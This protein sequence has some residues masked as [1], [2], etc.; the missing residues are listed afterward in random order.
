MNELREEIATRLVTK[1]GAEKSSAACKDVI[2]DDEALAM[3]VG[4]VAAETGLQVPD[5]ELSLETIDT[6]DAL[7]EIMIMAP[8]IVQDDTPA[9]EEDIA[10]EAPAEG[11]GDLSPVDGSPG[12]PYEATH[13]DIADDICAVIRQLEDGE[14]DAE[15]QEGDDVLPNAE[16]LLI[17]VL[18]D[19]ETLEEVVQQVAGHFRRKDV[20]AITLDSVGTISMLASAILVSELVDQD[21]DDAE[22]A[23]EEAT[24]EDTAP[25]A[26]PDGDEEIPPGNKEVDPPVEETASVV[27]DTAPTL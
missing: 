22:P 23:A 8:P 17:N 15:G 1:T 13:A 18:Q 7:T 12:T 3:L 5:A 19:Q 26:D 27:A 25:A 21:A 14:D 2:E 9:P 6:L 11:T 16:T 20:P 24:T 4:A 10:E